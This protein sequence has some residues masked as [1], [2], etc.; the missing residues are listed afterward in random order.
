MD[1]KRINPYATISAHERW[2]IVDS[3]LIAAKA[4]DAAANPRLR[5][6][7]VLHEGE[8]DPLQRM[9]NALQPGT[10]VQPHRHMHPPKAET[11]I[12]LSGRAGFL[13]FDDADPSDIERAERVLLDRDQGVFAVDIRPG[14]WHSLVCL[15]LDTV[16]FEVKNGPYAPHS[17]KDFAPWAPE[18]ETPQASDFLKKMERRF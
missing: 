17:D 15:A 9:V 12:I 6:I 10:Y 11:F 4:S 7:H 2:A 16:L 1:A 13:F 18:P 14:V 5:D 3:D 8:P